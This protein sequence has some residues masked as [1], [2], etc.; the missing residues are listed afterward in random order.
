MATLPAGDA[1][2][3][4]ITL[5]IIRGI[6]VMGIFSVNITAFAMIEGAYFN[7]PAYGGADGANLA[8]WIAN[9]IFIDGK[10]RSLFSMLFG[11]S[12]LLVIQRAAA[13]GE[14]PAKVHYARMLVLFV[15]GWLHYH[16]IWWGDILKDY[17]V[18][19]CLAYL[20][21]R[22]S[23]KKLM[24]WAI[25]LYLFGMLFFGSFIIQLIQ[26]DQAAHAPGATSAAITQWNDFASMMYPSA[27]EI[28]KDLALHRGSWLGIAYYWVVERP[29]SWVE[30]TLFFLPETLALMLFG[31]AGFKSGFLTG[32]WGNR[33]YV[34]WAAVGISLGVAASIVVAIADIKSHFFVPTVFGAFI[35]GLAP[36]RL[37]Q[38]AGYAA[39]IVLLTRNL[40]PLAERI[41]A[42]GRCAFTNYLGT[43]LIAAFVFYGWGLGYYGYA[44]RWQAWLLVP[45]VWAIMLLWSKPWL[46]RFHYGPLEWI[47]RTSARATVQPFRKKK[48]APA[49]AAA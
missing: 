40:G 43:S 2:K 27:A 42:T 34:K 3:R 1:S 19:G 15:I 30:G 7:P 10:M 39:L 44:A 21:H 33:R 38:A 17:A 20:W 28:S 47:W 32:E 14:S 37:V 18:T 35:V 41:A 49:A 26:W 5:D 23:M 48:P 13:N 4:I 8:L 16:L 45:A 29:F 46:E 22:A 11:A 24:G 25:G 9:L 12:M 36:F 6:A 31:M